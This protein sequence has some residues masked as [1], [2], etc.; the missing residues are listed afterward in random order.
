M[1][2]IPTQEEVLRLFTECGALR[3]GHFQTPSG[4]HSE[5]YLNVALAMRYHQNARTLG[6]ALSRKVRAHSELR[7]MISDLSIV[8][9]ATGGIP[10]A[11]SMCEA[12]HANQVYWAERDSPTSPLYF[13]QGISEKQGEKVLLV[14]D[15][16]RTG[17]RLTE[18]RNKVESMGDQVVGIAVM[19]YQPN[20]E[21]PS[22]DPL[23]FFY[24]ARLEG[25]YWLSAEHCELCKQG[26]PLETVKYY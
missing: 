12:L 11:Y 19:V 15:I 18:L 20:P 14:D 4:L 1:Q 2:L 25:K 22:F 9:P 5:A 17:R 6:V 7:A 3:Y 10:V 23:P 16:M 13:R 8:S 21:T 24:L 26:V